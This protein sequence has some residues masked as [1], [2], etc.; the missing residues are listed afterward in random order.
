LPRL[1]IDPPATSPEI[2]AVEEALG[3]PLPE[4]FREVLGTFSARVDVAWQLPK[5]LR[6]PEEFR[7]TI[8]G[9]CG[10]DLSRLTKTDQGRVEMM[11]AAFSDPSNRYDA[12]WHNKL[13]FHEVPNGDYFAFDLSV[14]DRAPV[15]Y[16]SHD[17]GNGHGYELGADFID[18]VDR[19]SRLGAPGSEDWRWLP[20]TSGPKSLLDPDGEAAKRWREWFGLELP[21]GDV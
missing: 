13:A 11:Q 4:A 18:F 16:L 8:A 9:D 1:S 10:W 21:A 3:F 17:D 20:F 14:P 6:P 19:Y 15:V 12:V 2:E 5:G 7:G